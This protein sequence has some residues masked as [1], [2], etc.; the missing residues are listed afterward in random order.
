[1][2]MCVNPYTGELMDLDSVPLSPGGA[3]WCHK[4]GLP[5]NAEAVEQYAYPG[6]ADDRENW[7]KEALERVKAI[8]AQADEPNHVTLGISPMTVVATAPVQPF[9]PSGAQG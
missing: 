6:P 4:T 9:N 7:K 8:E 1:M 2:R 3:K 5:L